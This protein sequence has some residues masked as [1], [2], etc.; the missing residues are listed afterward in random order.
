MGT[1]NVVW[2]C[3]HL[4]I[5]WWSLPRHW[6]SLFPPALL[7]TC[8]ALVHYRPAGPRLVLVLLMKKGRK[9]S[10]SCRG[11]ESSYFEVQDKQRLYLRRLPSLLLG[12]NFL[13]LRKLKWFSQD[14]SSFVRYAFF[15]CCGFLSYSKHVCWT[16]SITKNFKSISAVNEEIRWEKTS[17]AK[18]KYFFYSCYCCVWPAKLNTKMGPG[19]SEVLSSISGFWFRRNSSNPLSQIHNNNS[20]K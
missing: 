12:S 13:P 4:W 6:K 18:P 11:D 2:L 10:L 1:H 3:L 14:H 16:T 17:D 19:R 5:P 20:I 9:L 15:C 8:S 7:T